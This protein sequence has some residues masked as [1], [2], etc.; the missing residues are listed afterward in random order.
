M[1]PTLALMSSAEA[2]SLQPRRPPGHG[3]RKALAF[4]FDIVRLRGEGHSLAA[5]REAL[6]DAGVVVSVSTVHREAQRGGSAPPL[7]SPAQTSSAHRLHL[8]NAKSDATTT[9][10]AP[11]QVATS[12]PGKAIAEE[13]MRNRISNPLLRK[14]PAR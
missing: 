12:L 8:S 14:E 11:G 3:N 4:A 7:T 10:P 2:V 13:F 9:R 1:R 6:E 5:I